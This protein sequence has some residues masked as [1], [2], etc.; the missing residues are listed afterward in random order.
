MGCSAS[1]VSCHSIPFLKESD[2]LLL[3]K[4]TV[5]HTDGHDTGVS[6]S[7]ALNP[8]HVVYPRAIVGPRVVKYDPVSRNVIYVFGGVGTAKGEVLDEMCDTYGFQ[9]ISMEAVLLEQA[10]YQAN[11]TDH[12]KYGRSTVTIHRLLADLINASDFCIEFAMRCIVDKLDKL[13]ATATQGVAPCIVID[14]I[15]N[16]ADVLNCSAFK[17]ISKCLARYD[18]SEIHG[19]FAISLDDQH[20][21][22]S[23]SMEIH[24]SCLDSKICD[25][26]HAN[27]K[28]PQRAFEN[29]A[30]LSQNG[31]RGSQISQ[32]S[33]EGSR[34]RGSIMN[35]PPRQANLRDEADKNVRHRRS[36][37]VC[38]VTD[39]CVLAFKLSQRLVN[40]SCADPINGIGK[41]IS[42]L[43]GLL[44]E[45]DFPQK[46]H[47][48]D[49]HIGFD[50]LLSGQN[51]NQKG[52]SSQVTN[53]E[54]R[55]LSVV[56]DAIL[57][58]MVDSG[59]SNNVSL[60]LSNVDST[61]LVE[62]TVA[63]H[64][65][66]LVILDQVG[67]ELIASVIPGMTVTLPTGTSPVLCAAI[68]EYLRARM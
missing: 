46:H 55:R 67:A 28:I 37:L 24:R 33:G 11:Q 13:T 9:L 18:R 16:H 17:D 59:Y 5:S 21:R 56:L 30:R 49:L 20:N 1:T 14:L 31:S 39:P 2:V 12:S 64:K 44:N 45:L 36:Q 58:D 32:L 35:K 40:I 62:A 34:L 47:L 50:T 3:Q 52:I 26:E 48:G 53:S 29:S 66:H 23:I 7:V 43:R 68:V 60:D 19:K 63:N 8:Q 42:Q 4:D 6:E 51:D 10:S 25:T 15:P 65:R 22:D 57:A 38:S 54:M 61:H 27:S 41:A